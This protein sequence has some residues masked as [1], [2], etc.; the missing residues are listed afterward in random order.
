M[1]SVCFL[2]CFAHSG[3]IF[4]CV[5]G[6][7]TGAPGAGAAPEITYISWNRKVQH[8]LAST[9]VRQNVQRPQQQQQQG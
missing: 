2:L 1:L 4:L 7:T 9:Q 6:P 3:L 5:Q 8:I